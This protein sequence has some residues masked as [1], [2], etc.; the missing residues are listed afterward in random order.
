MAHWVCWRS[1]GSPPYVA[2]CGLNTVRELAA[3]KGLAYDPL[4][5]PKTQ[6]CK[7]EE[8]CGG[9]ETWMC[10]IANCN[11]MQTRE[12]ATVACRNMQLCAGL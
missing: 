3:D 10:L 7:G 8:R 5:Q 12:L 2:Y 11:H 1:N 6:A 4:A 9:G